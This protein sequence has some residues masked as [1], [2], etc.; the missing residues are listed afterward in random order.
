MRGRGGL[1]VFR[2]VAV[3]LKF[4]VALCVL[5]VKKRNSAFL[6]VSV[7]LCTECDCLQ[8]PS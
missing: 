5:R 2:V 6:R 1:C 4:A 8:V 7:F 3:L